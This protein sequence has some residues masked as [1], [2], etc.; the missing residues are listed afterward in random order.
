LGISLVGATLVVALPAP[1]RL[2]PT[3]LSRLSRLPRRLPPFSGGSLGV[4]VKV[5]NFVR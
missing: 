1:G 2:S 5:L 3:H 4:V